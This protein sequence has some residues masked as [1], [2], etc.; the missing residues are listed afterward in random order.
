MFTKD[1]IAFLDSLG[2]R[3]QARLADADPTTERLLGAIHGLRGSLASLPEVEHADICEIE[4]LLDAVWW[5]SSAGDCPRARVLAA[6]LAR[7]I[8]A[9]EISG[10]RAMRVVDAAQQIRTLVVLAA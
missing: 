3:A 10:L 2:T 6:R 5:A 1:D 7:R 9:L 8:R 4:D